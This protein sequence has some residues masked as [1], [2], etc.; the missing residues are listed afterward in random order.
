MILHTTS[1]IPRFTH[2][3]RPIERHDGAVNFTI[4]NARLSRSE[5]RR[6]VAVMID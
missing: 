5:L 2:N 6:L 4:G 3:P 1:A